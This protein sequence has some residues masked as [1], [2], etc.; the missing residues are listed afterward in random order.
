M[1]CSPSN[2]APTISDIRM[3]TGLLP[4]A[5]LI[6]RL[7]RSLRPSGSE[8]VKVP[9]WISL[10]E[11]GSEP[12]EPS[13]SSPA[14]S[15]R[16]EP[17]VVPGSKLI[18]G[19]P[20]GRSPANSSRRSNSGNCSAVGGSSAERSKPLPMPPI[21]A[22]KSPPELVGEL[23]ADMAPLGPNA[24][25]TPP[26]SRAAIRA[27]RG[28]STSPRMKVGTLAA[29]SLM[30]MTLP[31]ACSRTRLVPSTR[32]LST[33]TLAGRRTTFAASA[34]YSPGAAWAGA[35]TTGCGDCAGW[36]VPA[37]TGTGSAA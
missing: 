23:D 26:A 17:I 7:S 25:S 1:P 20:S 16:P 14:S 28:S 4:S 2:V 12:T 22:W 21:G 3:V 10:S 15:T 35:A 18:A 31:S 29:A 8:S 36:P 34:T 27:T 5:A 24:T 33:E 13:V 19:S 32:M 37:S 6:V 30:T 11:S 9:V